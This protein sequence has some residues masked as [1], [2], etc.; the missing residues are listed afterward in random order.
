MIS[1]P[2]EAV[3]SD[4]LSAVV[5]GAASGIGEAT[6]QRL[7]SDGLAI[8]GVDRDAAR[9]ESAKSAIRGAHVVGDVADRGILERAAE[10]AAGFGRLAVWV[11]CA[12]IEY[13]TRA[14]DLDENRFAEI[15]RVNVLG[16]ALG[17]SAA[18]ACFLRQGAPGSIVNVSSIHAITAF[19]SSFAYQASKGAVDALTRQLAI[20]Y[21]HLG[22]RCNAVRPGVIM[23]R[24][25]LALLAAS[26]DPTRE[27]ESWADI[28]ALR[29]VAEPAEVASVISFLASDDA[30][31]V[32]GAAID[33]DGGATARCY[34]YPPDPG[35]AWPR[36][37]TA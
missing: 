3:D 26:P 11:N 13:P 9:L 30:S 37:D 16:Y 22:I 12:G 1:Q 18:C 25:S 21:G 10:I 15:M 28:H 27:L 7:A 23:T 14:H 5:T 19:P 31:F 2:S 36:A 32:T 6:A 33:V 20:D 35:I 4:A 34:A 24:A 29:R 8:V 17:C